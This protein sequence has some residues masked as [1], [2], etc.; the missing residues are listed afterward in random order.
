MTAASEP[1][2]L[3]PGASDAGELRELTRL[4]KHLAG[5]PDCSRA[6]VTNPLSVTG[7]V[8][9]VLFALAAIFAPILAP[10]PNEMWNPMQIPR[11][12][13]RAE[14][15]PPMSEWNKELADDGAVVVPQY[16]AAAEEWVHLMGTTNGPYDIWYGV[17]WGAHGVL[18]QFR[19]DVRHH[20]FGR[21]CRCA[22]RLWMGMDR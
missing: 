20:A 21:Y 16:L 15:Q 2:V 22:G 5:G 6:F 10:P 9:I 18:R 12:G 11:D 7:I 3:R 8:L 19:G 13:F 14:P 17:V 4:E 1:V